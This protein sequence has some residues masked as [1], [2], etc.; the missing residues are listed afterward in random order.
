MRVGALILLAAL[1]ATMPGY[2][3]E[4]PVPDVP[5]PPAPSGDEVRGDAVGQLQVPATHPRI[6]VTAEELPGLRARLTASDRAWQMVQAAGG[7]YLADDPVDP[8]GHTASLQSRSHAIARQVA[9]LAFWGLITEDAGVRTRISNWFARLD[10]SKTEGQIPGTDYMPRGEFLLGFPLAYDWCKPWASDAALAVLRELTITHATICHDGIYEQKNWEGRTEAN[11]HSMAALGG[12]GLAG[13]ALWG[14]TPAARAW[15][16]LTAK[17]VQAYLALSFDGQGACYEGNLYGPFGMGQALPFAAALATL[18]GTDH[19]G[20]GQLVRTVHWCISDAI[21]GGSLLMN[22]LNDA[23]GQRFSA[24]LTLYAAKRYGD[25]LSAWAY[26][27]SDGRAWAPYVALWEHQLPDARAPGPEFNLRFHEGRGLLNVRTG[28]GDDDVFAS[29]EAGIRVKGCHGQSDQGQITLYGAG[30]WYAVDPGYSNK[31][32][33]DSGNQ[34]LAHNLVLIDGVGQGITGG[35]DVAQGKMLRQSGDAAAIVAVADLK[36]A[37]GYKD[38]NPVVKGLRTFVWIKPTAAAVATGMAGM[39]GGA[40]RPLVVVIDEIVKDAKAHTFTSKW[41]TGAGNAVTWSD[42]GVATIVPPRG[43]V[44]RVHLLGNKLKYATV[45]EDYGSYL[46]AHPVLTASGPAV[47][48]FGLQIFEFDEP[49]VVVEAAKKGKKLV[50][51]RTAAA[52]E[53]VETLSIIPGVGMRPAKLELVRTRA[54]KREYK[55]S[56]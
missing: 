54:K 8:Q 50:I 10:C 1:A 15:V 43:P 41:H 24:N 35:G 4:P 22:P 14:E 40:R 48:W 12:V 3:Q 2:A 47:A 53:V 27:K 11:N 28:F 44:L 31:K 30:G 5:T 13:L 16:T 45:E 52:T 39:S 46:K 55:K 33:A 9:T 18:G 23:S 6:L 32:E 21:P 49:G 36:P 20:E 37:Y 42:G 38:H 34:T 25:A 51:T 26:A 29:F 7:R 56:W 17:K 19:Y